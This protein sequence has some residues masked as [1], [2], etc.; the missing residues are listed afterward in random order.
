[1]REGIGLFASMLPPLTSLPGPSL[2]RPAAPAS[3]SESMHPTANTPSTTLGESPR[4]PEKARAKGSKRKGKGRSE[5]ATRGGNNPRSGGKGT[6]KPSKWADKCMYAELLEMNEDVLLE[7]LFSEV[8]GQHMVTPPTASSE[9]LSTTP[10]DPG[11]VGLNYPTQSNVFAST[12]EHEHVLLI[13]MV[14]PEL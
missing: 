11:N 3:S 2:E 5:H 8:H 10:N 1:M 7:P 14:F 4:S 12:H 13:P 9:L 6:A